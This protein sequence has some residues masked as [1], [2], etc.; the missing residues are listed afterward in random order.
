MPASLQ[1]SSLCVWDWD[2]AGGEVG[3]VARMGVGA[4][5]YK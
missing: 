4:D 3:C 1:L 5:G 2:Y